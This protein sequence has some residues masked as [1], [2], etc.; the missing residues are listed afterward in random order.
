MSE[1]SPKLPL[2]DNG[3]NAASPTKSRFQLKY[4]GYLVLVFLCGGIVGMYFQPP[5]LKAFFNITGLE[6]GGGSDTP[7]AVAV[8][9]LEAKET[10]SVISEGDVVA[11]GRLMP[12]GDVTTVAPPFG[13]GDARVETLTVKAGDRVMENQVLAKMD[14]FDQLQ[15]D[16]NSNDALVKLRKA[17]LQQTMEVTTINLNEASVTLAR[18]E[19]T[20]AELQSRLQRS[21]ELYKKGIIARAEYDDAQTRS[22]EAT[23]DVEK[24]KAALERYQP[25][26]GGIQTDILVA[27]ANLELALADL[28]RSE[29]SLEKAIVRAP[30]EGTILDINV[31]SGEKPGSEGIL[32]L[33]DIEN[34][35]VSLEVY[36]TFVGRVNVGD[37]VSITADALPSE[38]TG[39][40]SVIGLEIGK[41]SITSNDT[42]ANTDARVVD[43]IVTL[44]DSSSTLAKRYTHLEVIARID[45]EPAQ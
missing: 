34:M 25:Q 14:N 28:R 21:V 19:A 16:V 6:P 43:V 29:Q 11:L 18:A 1:E 26:D 20:S 3:K 35:A 13:A 17:N 27:E 36:Q 44:D 5:G 22:I 7:I 10:V 38:L 45:A 23:R 42:A 4:L 30:T 12:L 8:A 41:Q 2:Q 33:G 37:K 39:T 24:A 40:V 15:A 31:N 9:Q 32:E